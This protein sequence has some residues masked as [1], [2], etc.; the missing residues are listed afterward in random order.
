MSTVAK[1]SRSPLPSSSRLLVLAE[2]LLVFI[3]LDLDA[4]DILSCTKVCRALAD[5][6]EHTPAVQYKLQ[7]GLAGMV[8]GSAEDVPLAKR[9]EQLRAYHASWR[10][11]NIPTITVDGQEGSRARGICDGVI[12]YE[13]AT[14]LTLF[15]PASAFSG[16][17][18]SEVG[19]LDYGAH[20]ED[21]EFELSG[22]AVDRAQDLVV[23]TKLVLGEIPQMY[24]LSISQKGAFHPLA[25]RP[26]YEDLAELGIT[27]DPKERIEICGDLVAWTVQCDATS[28]TIINWKTGAVV[29]SDGEWPCDDPHFYMSCHFLDATDI[30]LVQSTDVYIC[31]VDPAQTN[32]TAKVLCTLKLP[33]LQQG[34]HAHNIE[35]QSRHP[36]TPAGDK[37]L[38]R[39][40]PARTVLALQFSACKNPFGYTPSEC[41]TFF[42]LVPVSTMLAAAAQCASSEAAG[43]VPWE[44]WSAGGPGTRMFECAGHP[45]YYIHTMGSACMLVPRSA[46]RAKTPGA[47]HTLLLD[48]HPMAAHAPCA[49]L[50]LV[51]LSFKPG[52]SIDE[53][54]WFVR[55]VLSTLPCRMLSLGEALDYRAYLSQD[56]VVQR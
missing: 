35:S 11:G 53:P 32:G 44:K 38:F 31:E 20:I 13:D 23:L 54:A 41:R 9:L 56:A 3:L 39:R 52:D 24:F 37:A 36:P 5:V 19:T 12:V 18:A 47:K 7:L 25:E 51:E 10:S 4:P 28:V 22:V 33:A 43:A 26:Q 50:G 17:V 55:P 14:R 2:E 27:V 21:P 46:E 16:I 29:F 49:P 30:A 45:N 34:M 15:R 1:L 6:I 48:A 42:A 40:D 8:D